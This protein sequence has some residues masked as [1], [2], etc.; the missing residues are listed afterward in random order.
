M[1]PP[2]LREAHLAVTRT[3]RYATLGEAGPRIREVWMACHG[4]GQLAGRFLRRFEALDDG[5]RLIVAPEALNRFYLDG[6]SG[7]HGSD[8][9]VGATWMTREDRLTDIEDYVRYLDAVHAAAF[10]ALERATV[11]FIAFG[12]SQGVATICRWAARTRV[13]IDHLILWAGTLPQ[14]LALSPDP[15]HGARLTIAFGDRDP[16]ASSEVVQRIQSAMKQAARE[17]TLVRYEGGHDIE[18]RSLL[19]IAHQQEGGHDGTT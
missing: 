15:F 4:Y 8:S 2:D 9:R 18:P 5:C 13:R 19:R 6:G 16:W 12:F 17:H 14:E 3:A 7:P 11:R 10:T 1:K